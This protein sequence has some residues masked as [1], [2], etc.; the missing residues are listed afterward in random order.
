MTSSSLLHPLRLSASGNTESPATAPNQPTPRQIISELERRFGSNL[1]PEVRAELR[2]LAVESDAGLFFEGLLGLAVREERADRLEFA[3]AL[4]STVLESGDSAGAA[5]RSRAQASLDA[6]VGRGA[7]GNRAEFLM[8]RFAREA[9]SPSMLIG[10][11]GAQAVFGVT[12]LAI[13]SRLAAS[14]T[15]SL[16]TRG[17]GARALASVGA[18]ALEAPSFVAFTRGANAAMGQSQDWSLAT[19]GREVASSYITLGSLKAAGALSTGIFNRVHGIN[20]LSGQATRLTGLSVVSQ[21]LLP[22]A[23]MLGGIVLGHN[24]ETRLGL[25]DHVDGATTLVDS[26]AMLLQFNVGGRLMSHALP[27]LEGVN[28]QLNLRSELLAHQ[29][30]GPSPASAATADLLLHPALAVAGAGGRSIP[31]P[32]E[33]R[34]LIHMMASR[35]PETSAEESPVPSSG[36]TS[37]GSRG[38][39]GSGESLPPPPPSSGPKSTPPGG[40]RGGF[41]GALI[42]NVQAFGGKFNLNVAL[43]LD[44]PLQPLPTVAPARPVRSVREGMQRAEALG[45][46]RRTLAYLRWGAHQ[47]RAN[48]EVQGQFLDLM[49]RVF[50]FQ[51]RQREALNPVLQGLPEMDFAELNSRSARYDATLAHLTPGSGRHF[52]EAILLREITRGWQDADIFRALT[53]SQLRAMGIEPEARHAIARNAHAFELSE[54]RAILDHPLLRELPETEKLREAAEGFHTKLGQIRENLTGVKQTV[55][56]LRREIA[57]TEDVELQQ[58]HEA[59]IR[60]LSQSINMPY[61]RAMLTFNAAMKRF[62][63]DDFR[64]RV[65]LVE[66]ARRS[67]L[68]RGL[69][70]ANSGLLT[71]HVREHLA[72]LSGEAREAASAYLSAADQMAL[73]S[74]RTGLRRAFYSVLRVFGRDPLPPLEVRGR[75]ERALLGLIQQAPHDFW[76]FGP[77]DLRALEDAGR[78]QTEYYEGLAEATARWRRGFAGV[79]QANDAFWA[80]YDSE[81][82][83]LY[84]GDL[85]LQ[86]AQAEQQFASLREGSQ[87]AEFQRLRTEAE[88]AIQRFADPSTRGA[89]SRDVNRSLEVALTKVA[90]L[91]RFVRAGLRAAGDPAAEF[92]AVS[93]LMLPFA[94]KIDSPGSARRLESLGAG[95]PLLWRT[96]FRSMGLISSLEHGESSSVLDRHFLNWAAGVTSA[97]GSRFVADPNVDRLVEAEPVVAAG[98]H[99]A[100]LDFLYGGTPAARAAQLRGRGT[101][102]DAMRIGAKDGLGKKIGPVI[103]RAIE[104]LTETVADSAPEYD[105]SVTN[106]ARAMAYGDMPGARLGPRSAAVYDE[107]T[108]SVASLVNPFGFDPFPAISSILNPP[109]G[110]RSFNIADRAMALTARPQNL[111]V[112]STLNS[113]RLWP[114][115]DRPL[116]L[117]RGPTVTATQFVPSLVLTDAGGEG[118]NGGTRANLLRTLW[119]NL[120]T[121]PEYQR[122]VSSIAD[123]FGPFDRPVDLSVE[124]AIA[125]RFAGLQEFLPSAEGIRALEGEKSSLVERLR[126]NDGNVERATESS[127]ILN[128]L[129]RIDRLLDLRTRTLLRNRLTELD[130]RAGQ[131]LASGE[132]P[133]AE[134]AGLRRLQR[135]A[136]ARMQLLDRVEA[137]LTQGRALDRTETSF[138]ERMG[139]AVAG[140]NNTAG[141]D[142]LVEQLD[143]YFQL[144]AQGRG[145]RENLTEAQNAY[146][147]FV[148]N[149]NERRKNPEN[150]E[151]RQI[152]V[153]EAEG[154][155]AVWTN[156]RRAAETTLNVYGVTP[157]RWNGEIIPDV[158]F[159][160]EGDA[161]LVRPRGWKPSQEFS[162]GSLWRFLLDDTIGIVRVAKRLQEFDPTPRL[163]L[164]M[165]GRGWG[166]RML[167]RT[168]TQLR[169]ENTE[170]LRDLANT[171]SVVAPTHDSGAEF[172]TVPGVVQDY[173]LHAFF[174]ADRK[175]FDP[176]P[177]PPAFGLIKALLGPMDQY[178]H[179][180]IDR[181]DR[182]AAMQ[183]MGNAGRFIRDL[184]RSIIIFPGGTRNPVRYDEN[185]ER[186][187]GPIY[188]NRPGVAMTME[189]SQAP[190]LPIGLINGG[191]IFP[192]QNGD[193]F[194]GRGAAVGRTYT[195]RF[196]TPLL[197]DQ[198]VP[199]NPTPRGPTLRTAVTQN[200]DRQFHELTGR[201]IAPPA[202]SKAKKR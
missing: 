159:I 1:R 152:H 2:S 113:Y 161:M 35:D 160:R 54:L 26:L 30:T 12:R 172:M 60:E 68:T 79:E 42:R 127:A 132:I 83:G 116:P 110:G 162:R 169:I 28:Q 5:L 129:E 193:A 168:H 117:R 138:V 197:Y 166:W 134:T 61:A 104:L 142:R 41:L 191:V 186:Y 181:S 50:E 53:D 20:P 121:M 144:R 141:I 112:T 59:R 108:M 57:D 187:E 48:P 170:N 85:R 33:P 90:E 70:E 179:L 39:S 167:D 73:V 128:E 34:D 196:G 109:Q 44:A 3:G 182:R 24:L 133:S 101:S 124:T 171:Q 123:T 82:N 201:E 47:L 74:D 103:E 199:G 145:L 146:Y 32:L 163:Y 81:A 190:I 107:L 147:D 72:S 84:I 102:R 165:H 111:L 77:F 194:L 75:Y 120:G 66:T 106:L 126:E 202:E 114:K 65:F 125:Q 156:Y 92:R 130:L 180:A 78:A 164:T 175:F 93:A 9:S 97:T 37:R 154:Y 15:S 119:L 184:G 135:V 188:G 29:P 58:R 88:E 149:W 38:P 155:D 11:A 151:Y 52:G 86:L 67:S 22:Q 25:R 36:V 100:W 89:N 195:F 76:E 189:E 4:Y 173:G 6:I 137:K 31:R 14:P 21:R 99:N 80:K 8:R 153:S 69:Q 131:A 63:G 115:P 94:D 192:K 56:E 95:W 158:D 51:A 91:R 150:P 23:G 105:G 148:H 176:F 55:K 17:V 136:R 177:K 178:G 18:F 96:F 45:Q 43:D 49:Q 183:V 27:H 198:V 62:M 143:Y 122:E 98:N 200:L 71:R 185:G 174:M 64:A 118:K 7:F 140:R 19:L 40:K 139:A 157:G 16:I 10:M 13:L 46:G 87:A